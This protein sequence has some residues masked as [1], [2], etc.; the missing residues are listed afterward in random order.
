[1]KLFLMPIHSIVML[2]RGQKGGKAEGFAALE[3]L[4]QL[5][6]WSGDEQSPV[7]LNCVACSIE[8]SV[9]L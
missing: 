8:E 9:R 5:V 2:D 7:S 3:V 6:T 1:M 4:G